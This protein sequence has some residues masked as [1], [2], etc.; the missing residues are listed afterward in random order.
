MLKLLGLRFRLGAEVG[1]FGFKDLTPREAELKGVS[2]VILAAIPAGPGK[3]KMGTGIFGKS[4]G[5]VFEATYGVALGSL[6]L[7]L[8]LRS[9]ELISATDDKERS[10]GHLGWMDSVVALGVNF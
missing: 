10:L 4:M 9:T 3:I 8:G 7:R 6:D 2:T 1:T 5:F